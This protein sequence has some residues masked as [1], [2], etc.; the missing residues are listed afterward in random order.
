MLARASE[1]KRH[2]Q[3]LCQFTIGPFFESAVLPRH[4][5]RAGTLHYGA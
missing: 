5:V 1:R 2:F 4:N 3:E